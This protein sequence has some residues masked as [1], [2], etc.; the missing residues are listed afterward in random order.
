MSH[1]WRHSWKIAVLLPLR[2]AEIWETLH[3]QYIVKKTS[4]IEP[5]TIEIVTCV[6][7]RI[8]SVLSFNVNQWLK[9]QH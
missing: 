6:K 9:S 1:H 2:Y 4:R 7:F 8:I 3:H 5:L